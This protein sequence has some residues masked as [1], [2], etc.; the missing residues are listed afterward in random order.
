M[1]SLILNVDGRV[2]NGNLTS[3]R[4]G[5]A[6]VRLFDR[7][8][9][10]TVAKRIRTILDVERLGMHHHLKIVKRLA[11]RLAGPK[12]HNV[13]TDRDRIGIRVSS[14]VA[15]TVIHAWCGITKFSKSINQYP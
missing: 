6:H 4:N 14:R 7:K 3:R 9:C 2:T 8:I 5:Q 1:A 11:I 12:M 10:L 13:V 15:E